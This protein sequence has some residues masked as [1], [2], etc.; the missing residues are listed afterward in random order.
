M[1]SWVVISLTPIFCLCDRSSIRINDYGTYRHVSRFAS[2]L[3]QG[4]RSLHP[5]PMSHIF[6][7]VKGWKGKQGV[8]REE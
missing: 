6:W 5:L 7:M 8:R 2:H 4:D 3:S 1:G